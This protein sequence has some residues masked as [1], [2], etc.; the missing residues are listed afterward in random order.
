[1]NLRLLG[2]VADLKNAFCQSDMMHRV[3]GD[4]YVEPCGG[5]PLEPGSLIRLLVN[6]YGL[7]NAPMAWRRTVTGFLKQHGFTRS[8]LEPCWWV[9]HR[10]GATA[11]MIPLEAGDLL[12][13]SAA[14]TDRS[15][16]RR[17]LEKRFELG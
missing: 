14:E 7:G 12:I 10:K 9:R 13:G 15:W 4:L 3:Q 17:T 16:L 8:L 6:V 2:D 1:M 5:V 11:N